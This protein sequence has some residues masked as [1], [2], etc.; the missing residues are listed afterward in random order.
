MVACAS[1]SY[2]VVPPTYTLEV[3]NQNY[4]D[5][6]VYVCH[7]TQPERL[8]H[9]PGLSTRTLTYRAQATERVR[10]IIDFISA[11]AV[12]SNYVPADNL[13]L[14]IPPDMH[15]SVVRTSEPCRLPPRYAR[16][17]S[18]VSFR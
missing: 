1:S 18:V 2:G 6:T 8:G 3:E 16:T 11:G 7:L 15:H 5:A 14:I 13:E 12:P 9:V 17:E 4:Y 10:F